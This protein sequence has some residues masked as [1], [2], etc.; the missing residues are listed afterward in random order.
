MA[1]T[2][3][4]LRIHH[5]VT[6]LQDMV[7]LS[8]IFLGAG[9]SAV[10]RDLS[11]DVARREIHI[12]LERAGSELDLCFALDAREGPRN[13][14][15]REYFAMGDCI[16]PVKQIVTPAPEDSIPQI[17]EERTV[18][19]PRSAVDPNW[20]EQVVDLEKRG[21]FEEAA[22]LVRL[23]LPRYGAPYTVAEMYCERMVRLKKD[24]DEAG[25]IFCFQRADFWIFLYASYATSGGEG[26]ALTMERK[27]F[28]ES[29]VAHFGRDP[30][31]EPPSK[32]F[33]LLP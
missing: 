9:E 13:G 20:F 19:V 1:C 22:S 3:D 21:Q 31:P 28:R 6:A 2:I 14:H 29:L 25:A 32:P 16:L 24:G 18:N 33:S 8:G 10:L 11:L 5:H 27:R 4:H 17:P 26:A 7:D 30:D 12:V 23:A 15:M